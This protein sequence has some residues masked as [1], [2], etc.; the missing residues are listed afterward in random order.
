MDYLKAFAIGGLLCAVGQILIDK[1][2]LTPA[3]ILTAYV[4]AGVILG[5]AGVY[6]EGVQGDV[7]AVPAQGVQQLHRVGGGEAHG[8]QLLHPCEHLGGSAVHHQSA[9]I[10]DDETVGVHG[11]VHMVGDED[12][13]DVPLFI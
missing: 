3:R 9:V 10:H 1:T 13:G 8:P 6:G 5:G 7:E 12:H 2:K 11:L 4:V